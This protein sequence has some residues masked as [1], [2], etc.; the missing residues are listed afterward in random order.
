M[1]MAMV[2]GSTFTALAVGQL[3]AAIKANGHHKF[4]VRSEE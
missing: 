3:V 4:E 1:V 2:Q